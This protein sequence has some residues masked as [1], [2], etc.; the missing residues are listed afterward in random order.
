[1]KIEQIVNNTKESILR[2]NFDEIIGAILEKLDT[3][4][5]NYSEEQIND[6]FESFK[7]IKLF[8]TPED[9]YNSIDNNEKKELAKILVENNDIDENDI[10]SNMS[11]D[12]IIYGLS[13]Y[14][15][16]EMYNTLH[17]KYGEDRDDREYSKYELIVDDHNSTVYDEILAK[18]LMVINSNRFKLTSEEEEFIEKLSKRL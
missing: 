16:K 8:P 14:D 11:V 3:P 2:I 4:I 9:Y 1:M 10:I 6:L 5:E 15:E 12:D 13:S 17:D 18:Q 7:I